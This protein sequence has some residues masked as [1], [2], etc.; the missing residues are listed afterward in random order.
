LALL[1]LNNFTSPATSAAARVCVGEPTIDWLYESEI[2][3]IGTKAPQ[4]AAE[5]SRDEKQPFAVVYAHEPL[6][7]RV[8]VPAS[9]LM[10]KASR[11]YA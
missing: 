2:P 4:L 7:E 8:S 5:V 1:N 9:P 10:V 11:D 6:A 3:F